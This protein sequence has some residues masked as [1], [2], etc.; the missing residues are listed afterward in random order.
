MQNYSLVGKY[1]LT[2]LCLSQNVVKLLKIPRQ[3][4]FCQIHV[5]ECNCEKYTVSISFKFIAWRNLSI[6]CVY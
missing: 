4:E 1:H 3:R 5:Y 6:H 2:S